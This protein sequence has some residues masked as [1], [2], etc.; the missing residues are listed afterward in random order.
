MGVN[1]VVCAV[2]GL[3]VSGAKIKI[4]MLYAQRGCRRPP[5]YS[6]ARRQP[7]RCTAKRKSLS[8]I[9]GGR[10]TTVQTCPSRSISD[11]IA[12]C[13]AVGSAPSNCTTGR[14]VHSSSKP[15]CQKS[16]YSIQY[17]TATS[18]GAHHSFLIGC[19]DWLNIT[20]IDKPIFYLYNLIKTGK[21]SIGAIVRRRRILFAE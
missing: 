12:H 18:R 7:V 6:S 21:E 3:G 13:A 1:V 16:R 8:Y 10:S 4:I 11:Y 5:P 2:F 20:R 14:A 19:I 15:G 9:S 17:C